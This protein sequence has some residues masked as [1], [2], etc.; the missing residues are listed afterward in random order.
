M[1]RKGW[2]VAGAAVL[3][4]L[5]LALLL[6]GLPAKRRMDWNRQYDLG[7]RCLN[8]T[9]YSEA[10]L[11]FTGAIQIDAR[12][13]EAYL[14]AAEACLGLGDTDGAREFLE[15]G[16]ENC[17]E[18][19]TLRDRLEQLESSDLPD[20][21]ENASQTRA[22]T[23]QTVTLNS[24]GEPL[25]GEERIYDETGR[26]TGLVLL[27][28]AGA[29]T[30]RLE[31]I[32]DEQG[33]CTQS[34]EVSEVTGELLRRVSVYG[35][36]EKPVRQELYRQDGSLLEQVLF[37][38]DE[39]ENLVREERQSVQGETTSVL[40]YEWS[41]GRLTAETSYG[42]DGICSGSVQYFYDENGSLVREDRL[43]GTGEP[44]GGTLYERDEDGLCC[45]MT[46]LGPDGAATLW[47][48]S[49]YDENGLLL[50]E[51][52]KMPGGQVVWTKEYSRNS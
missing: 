12:R 51:T 41:E 32:Y 8:E 24:A 50:R 31:F 20:E 13:P 35:D 9:R 18:D 38:Y 40:E 17:G 21:P 6:V 11:A 44:S 14:G 23:V 29:E 27:D 22:G 37:Q 39:Q 52:M 42:V 49:E 26:Q 2:I 45:K 5:L 47:V 46:Y 33:R 25:S 34:G 19:D 15:Q 36:G 10:L 4:L 43:L 28:G 7:I 3:L 30:A 1:K 16:L 48:E